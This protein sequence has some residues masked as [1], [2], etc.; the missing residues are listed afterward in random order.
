MPRL[1]PNSGGGGDDPKSVPAGR[2]VLA[3]VWLKRQVSKN[4]AN[5][6]IRTKLEICEG[7]LKGKGRIS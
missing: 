3:M 6:Y 5:D 1:G 7:P 2:Y 4:T